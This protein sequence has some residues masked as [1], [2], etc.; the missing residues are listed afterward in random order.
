MPSNATVCNKIEFFLDKSFPGLSDHESLRIPLGYPEAKVQ[1]FSLGHQAL[2][3]PAWL[4]EGLKRGTEDIC[5]LFWLLLMLQSHA[6]GGEETMM[7]G[8]GMEV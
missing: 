8:G 2:T 5:F 4:E 1:R 3:G 7:L 6:Y